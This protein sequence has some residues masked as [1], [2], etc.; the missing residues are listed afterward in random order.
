MKSLFYSLISLSLLMLLSPSKAEILMDPNE[1]SPVHW[2]SIQKKIGDSFKQTYIKASDTSPE[3]SFGFSVA[4][5]GDTLVVGTIGSEA[6]YV[7]IYDKSRWVQQAYLQADNAIPD[8]AFGR[9]V[10]IDGDTIAIASVN[11]VYTFKR[12]GTTWTQQA[13][14]PQKGFVFSI[15]LNKETLAVGMPFDFVDATPEILDDNVY[16]MGFVDVFKQN[17]DNW[18]KEF[19]L[20]VSGFEAFGSSVALENNTLVVGAP[21]TSDDD[22]LTEETISMMGYTGKAYIFERNNNDWQLLTTLTPSENIQPFFGFK[23]ALSNNTIAVSG[24]SGFTLEKEQQEERVY[25]FSKTDDNWQQT[26]SLKASNSEVGD[27]FGSELA[28][29]NNTLIVGASNEDGQISQDNNEAQNSGAVY[30]FTQTKGT[31]SQQAY[32]KAANVDAGDLFGHSLALSG[33][34][35]VVGSPFEDGDFIGTGSTEGLN[36]NSLDSGSVLS[37]ELDLSETHKTNIIFDWIE[38]FFALFFPNFMDTF[39]FDG[40]LVRGPYP[41]TGNYIGTKNGKVYVSGQQWGGLVEVGNIDDIYQ[42]ALEQQ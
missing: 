13:H 21:G 36:N 39:S 27:Q 23:V 18:S 20:H 16:F 19:N 33:D 26:A 22:N 10:A 14:L 34:L 29:S 3:D 15:A 30:V 1:L 28:L 24:F 12:T 8:N 4:L 41:R 32:I 42:R 38:R 6:A 31:W 2:R 37:M 35:L 7:F 17:G 11:H 25:L 9:L 5:S 40:Y